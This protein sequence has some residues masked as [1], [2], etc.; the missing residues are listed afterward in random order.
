MEQITFQIDETSLAPIRGLEIRANFE[1][2]KAALEKTLSSY[3]TQIVTE[4][5]ISDAK[6]ALANIRKLKNSLEDARKTVKKQYLQPYTDFEAQYKPVFDVCVAAENNIDGQV[7]QY[8]GAQKEKKIAELRA[9]FDENVKDATGLIDFDAI[10]NPR[11]ENKGYDIETAK[12]DIIRE[13]GVTLVAANSIAAL[14]SEFETELLD[15]YRRTRDLAAVLRKNEN[16]MEVKRINERRKQEQELRN[17][18]AQRQ[19][20]EY[21]TQI[22]AQKA[23]EVRAEAAEN[24]A[25]VLDEAQL[26]VLDFRVWVTDNQMIALRNFLRQ[27]GIKYGKVP[28]A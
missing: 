19:E 17:A 2:I 20:T 14:H 13:I 18:E 27:N 4:D 15:E 3:K 10:F 1:E 26:R 5:G 8:D 25:E 22:A 9:F 28:T 24:I 12:S 6:A 21:L 11:W 7:K 16:L 23:E